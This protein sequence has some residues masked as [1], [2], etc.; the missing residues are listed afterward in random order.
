M[1]EFNSNNNFHPGI[2][3]EYSDVEQKGFIKRVIG[4]IVSPGETM[5]VLIA[6]PRILFPIILMAVSM[7]GFY[8]LRFDLYKDFLKQAMEMQLA[9]NPNLTRESIESIMPITTV[10][11]LIGAPFGVLLNWVIISAILFGIMKFFKGEGSFK[12]YLSI[13]GY[14]Y[15]IMFI[16]IILSAVSSYFTNSI[17]FNSSLTNITNLFMPDIK[18]SYLYGILRGVDFFTIWHYVVIGIGIALVSKVS[19]S[20]VYSVLSLIFIATVLIGAFNL[21]IY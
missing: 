18:G 12:Q 13:T 3:D 8:L 19:K 7:L 1:E 11:G 21:K 20:K 15:V 16:F 2:T 14:S 9:N 4:I 6:K 10:S 5:K 17:M